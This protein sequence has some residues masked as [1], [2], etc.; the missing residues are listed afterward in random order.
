[1]QA[2]SISHGNRLGEVEQD[3]F[4][5]IPS[6]T[7]AASMPRVEIESERSCR[8]FRWPIPGGPMN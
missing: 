5:L 1:L 8:I 7:D 3:I 6:Q 4:A 2:I